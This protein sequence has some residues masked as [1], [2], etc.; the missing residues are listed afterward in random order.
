MT[1]FL[2]PTLSVVLPTPIR[3]TLERALASVEAAGALPT[4][5]VVLGVDGGKD[6]PD[7]LEAAVD[8]IGRSGVS[9]SVLVVGTPF[10]GDHGNTVRN[11][12]L[13][14]ARGDFVCYMDDDDVFA[15]GALT[16]VRAAVAEAPGRPHLFRFRS[17]SG[18][19]YWAERYA[20]REGNVG[21]HCFV[22]PNRPDRLAPWST[23]YQGDFDHIAETVALYPD[24]EAAVVWREE[25][26]ART[27]PAS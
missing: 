23:R 13:G 2:A 16:V 27:R 4:D 20:L 17:H 26:I 18:G 25:I 15:E 22:T 3:P 19:L 14:H 11:A 7:L 12:C 5:E 9:C 10:Y 8:A 21:G 1:A 24:G 6:D